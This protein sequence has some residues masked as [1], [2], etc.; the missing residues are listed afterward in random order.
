L[1]KRGG[2]VD[3][4]LFYGDSVLLQIKAG[5]T[6]TVELRKYDETGAYTVI[7]EDNTETYTTFIIY[8]YLITFN[9]YER[10]YLQATSETS[11]WR[12]EW[13]DVI[14]EDTSMMLLQ[15]TNYDDMSDTFEFDY[16]TTLAV[17]NVN[18]MRLEG[19]MVTYKPAGESTIYDNQNEKSKIKG[20]VYRKL[21]FVADRIP[22][23]IAEIITI[24]TQHDRFVANSAG[25]IAEDLPEIEM[26]GAFCEVSIDLTLSL[27]LGINTHDIGLDCDSTTNNMIQNLTLLNKTGSQQVTGGA[28]YAINQIIIELVTGT[29]VTV[30]IG[31][32]V[33]GDEILKTYTLTSTKYFNIFTRNYISFD[34]LTSVYPIYVT[35]SGGNMNVFIQTIKSDS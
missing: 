2:K 26:V 10:L 3:Q 27:A 30:K 32:T 15:W 34:G 13:V 1:S 29:T 14:A 25:Y 33:G 19:E 20:N 18:F 35:I 9:K 24:A 8:E 28:G 4:I 23:Q 11:E 12:S 17:A 22:R 5:L 7:S 21:T 6:A 16:T 31:I